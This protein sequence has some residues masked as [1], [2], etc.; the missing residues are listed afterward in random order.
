MTLQNHVLQALLSYSTVNLRSLF[1]I[2]MHMTRMKIRFKYYPLQATCFI[3]FSTF[4]K[5]IFVFGL[6]QVRIKKTFVKMYVM[7]KWRVAAPSMHAFYL[8]M[9]LEYLLLLWIF[10]EV[11]SIVGSP[12]SFSNQRYVMFWLNEPLIKS[13]NF[14][15]Q[16]RCQHS[17][18]LV[19]NIKNVNFWYTET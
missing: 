15:L 17:V 2:H 6:F 10:G 11:Y 18:F 16:L 13:N 4:F 7:K 19:T 3:T 1:C 12:V 9:N 8:T 14:S 5:I